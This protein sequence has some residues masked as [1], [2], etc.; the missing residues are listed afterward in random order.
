MM[1]RPHGPIEKSETIHESAAN[2]QVVCAR[3]SANAESKKPPSAGG[4]AGVG[5]CWMAVRLG[6]YANDER[7]AHK[8]A[9]AN[10]RNGRAR[11]GLTRVRTDR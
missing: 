7:E 3:S 4:R 10:S 5:R 11:V 9:R 8:G 6:E 2:E 1:G